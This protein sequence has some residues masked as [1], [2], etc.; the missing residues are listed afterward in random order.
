MGQRKAS[1]K[2][3]RLDTNSKELFLHLLFDY[4]SEALVGIIPNRLHEVSV[5]TFV[6]GGPEH[7]EYIRL[8]KGMKE[9]W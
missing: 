4:F 6:W 5:N 3:M 1:S 8:Q 2:E 9:W 7:T